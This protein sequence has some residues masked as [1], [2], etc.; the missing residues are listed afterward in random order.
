MARPRTP[1]L[2]RT[3]IAAAALRLVD[4][5]GT[6]TIPALAAALGVRPSALYHH[7][8]GRA[9]II[10]LLR[11]DLCTSIAEGD[12]WDQPWEPALT[13]WAHSYRDAFAAHPGLVSLLA[14]APL[15]EPFLHVMYDRAVAVLRDAGFAEKATLSVITA[16]ESFVL[17]SA[18]DLVAPSVMI[19]L[20]DQTATPHLAG[21]LAALPSRPARADQAFELGLRAQLAGYR[22]LLAP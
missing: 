10:A 5:H 9:G 16:L 12:Y 21:A 3:R 17:G 18:L 15:T 22:T 2:D 7:V 19:D 4:D 8:D 1:L 11:E 14:T 6:L 20:V 13:A